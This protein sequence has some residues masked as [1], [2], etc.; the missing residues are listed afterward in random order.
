MI[1]ATGSSPYIAQTYVHTFQKKLIFYRINTK[2]NYVQRHWPWG[3]YGIDL[4][5]ENLLGK[6][7]RVL[8]IIYIYIKF[9]LIWKM[10]VS[11]IANRFYSIYIHIL[12][13][14]ERVQCLENGALLLAPF[15]EKTLRGDELQ[16][17]IQEIF[18]CRSLTGWV[19]HFHLPCSL[20]KMVGDI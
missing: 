12:M 11:C 15:P 1:S 6:K 19:S 10:N 13:Y 16:T 3:H 14:R 18:R 20:E 7:M 4:I 5:A 2:Q 9:I 8:Y 17:D